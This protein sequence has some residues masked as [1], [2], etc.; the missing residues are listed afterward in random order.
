MGHLL[1]ITIFKKNRYT[2]FS[3]SNSV[4]LAEVLSSLGK[5]QDL[6]DLQSHLDQM[7]ECCDE[8]QDNLKTANSATKYLLE[9]AEGLRKEG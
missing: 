7:K 1:R 8:I 6:I 3:G 5:E 4:W 2:L 9:H